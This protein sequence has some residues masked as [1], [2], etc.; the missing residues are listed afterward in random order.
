MAR[1]PGNAKAEALL[2]A[3]ISSVTCQLR[4][5]KDQMGLALDLTPFLNS[6]PIVTL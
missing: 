2:A 1:C 4:Y 6:L 3:N 5:S